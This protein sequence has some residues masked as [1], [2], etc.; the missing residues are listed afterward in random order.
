MFENYEKGWYGSY[1]IAGRESAEKYHII[2]HKVEI[3]DN[4]YK[5]LKI[6]DVF[7]PDLPQHIESLDEKL[8][9]FRAS[10]EDK[11]NKISEILTSKKNKNK[12][13]KNDKYKYHNK[14]IEEGKKN[15]KSI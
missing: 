3:L 14:H 9:I 11:N 1:S 10:Y 15:K 5:K 7:N 2:I 4:E 12:L 8:D 13:L 6:K